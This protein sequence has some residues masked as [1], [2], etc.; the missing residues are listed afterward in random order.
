MEKLYPNNYAWAGRTA[1]MYNVFLDDLFDIGVSYTTSNTQCTTKSSFSSLTDV[2]FEYKKSSDSAYTRVSVVKDSYKGRTIA[3]LDYIGGTVTWNSNLNTYVEDIDAGDNIKMRRYNVQYNH[4]YPCRVMIMGLEPGVSYDLRRY[5]IANNVLHTDYEQTI[6]LLSGTNT[7]VCNGFTF[8]S[9]PSERQKQN[10]QDGVNQ[11]I[12]IMDM[13]FTGLEWTFTVKTIWDDVPWS[14]KRSMRY[15]SKY[16]YDWGGSADSARTITI[17]EQA[18]NY[19]V[20][21]YN[22]S[23]KIIKFME[24]A[25]SVPRAT[26]KWMGEHNYPVISSN[27]YTY[28]DDC[29]VAAA[30]QVTRS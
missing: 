18:H 14:A 11:A 3:N 4:I 7:I 1:L 2:G 25:T 10:L 5:Y 12:V 24:F 20:A 21:T 23:D 19:M 28:I 9:A 27:H 13:W 26:W 30:C 22:N 16:A 6:T 15:N 29:L 8:D 17:H